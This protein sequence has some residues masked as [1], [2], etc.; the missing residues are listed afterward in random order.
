MLSYLMMTKHII[1]LY[2]SFYV[3]NSLLCTDWECNNTVTC[4]GSQITVLVKPLIARMQ[5]DVFMTCAN[6]KVRTFS[7]SMLFVLS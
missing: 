6:Q 7:N 2:V 5:T 1:S 3:D 4:F